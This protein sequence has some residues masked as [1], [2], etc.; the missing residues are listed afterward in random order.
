MGIR[1][2]SEILLRNITCRRLVQHGPAFRHN[3]ERCIQCTQYTQNTLSRSRMRVCEKHN[4]SVLRSHT[5]AR[6]FSSR[7]PVYIS[8]T[9]ARLRRRSLHI[10]A[11][12]GHPIRAFHA[13]CSV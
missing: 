13:S 9:W 4:V 5:A 11:T 6:G 3:E 12:G 2:S 1:G 8:P 10:A 7:K